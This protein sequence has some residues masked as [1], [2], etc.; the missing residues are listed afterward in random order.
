[1][2][3][4]VG[5]RG[6]KGARRPRP[7]V[8]ERLSVSALLVTAAI[9]LAAWRGLEAAAGRVAMR[10]EYH[11][12]TAWARCNLNANTS[13]R[14]SFQ[15]LSDGAAAA[16]VTHQTED[17]PYNAIPYVIGATRYAAANEYVPTRSQ[18]QRFRRSRVSD[19]Q[20]VSHFNPY[21]NYVDGRDGLRQPSTDDLI[22]WAAHKWG[23]PEG[24]LRAEYVQESFWSA[25][26]QGDEAKVSPGWYS[27]YPVQARVPRSNRVYQSLGITQVKWIPDGSVGAGTEP[28]RW[29]STAFNIDYQA[30]TVRFYYDNPQGRRSAWRDSGYRACQKWN[31]IGG[32]FEPFPWGNEG[33]QHYIEAVRQHLAGRDWAT[34]SFA[35]WTPP[36]F[37]PGIR[38]TAIRATQSGS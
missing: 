9:G 24:W 27:R 8:G 36:S 12:Q 2:S 31:S 3:E 29:E 34:R 25:L 17:R 38:F 22:Q 4:G 5:A 7:R 26:A 30:A 37:P 1:M 21:F 32:W 15:P 35:E 6:L 20:S 16:L 23:I 28:L 19:G 18:I 10:P 13:K 14:S 11:P 33:Q